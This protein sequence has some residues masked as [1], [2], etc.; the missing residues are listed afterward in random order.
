MRGLFISTRAFGRRSLAP[1]PPRTAEDSPGQRTEDS[2][3][4]TRRAAEQLAQRRADGPVLPQRGTEGARDSVRRRFPLVWIL[5]LQ[6]VSI[7]AS[8]GIYLK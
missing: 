3:G 6:L 7:L 2:R 1:L 4:P 8:E 5:F